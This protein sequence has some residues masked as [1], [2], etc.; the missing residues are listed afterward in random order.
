MKEDFFLNIIYMLYIWWFWQVYSRQ[1]GLDTK[2]LFVRLEFVLVL[3]EG[4]QNCICLLQSPSSPGLKSQPFSDWSLQK[5]CQKQ[6][7]QTISKQIT[8]GVSFITK[9]QSNSKWKWEKVNTSCWALGQTCFIPD[10]GA[11]I[12]C[13][14]CCYQ[15]LTQWQK[16]IWWTPRNEMC[17]VIW[18]VEL[19]PVIWS[20]SLT[21]WLL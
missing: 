20:V 13:E 7:M 21:W 17:A 15:V 19:L 6:I 1:L 14:A 16:K 12:P 5:R 9:V 2:R 3:N 4:F 18:S 8:L 10:W 11:V